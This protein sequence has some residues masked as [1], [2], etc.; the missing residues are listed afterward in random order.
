M[1]LGSTEAVKAAVKAGL[2]VSL[3][4]ISAVRDEVQNGSL[5]A[6]PVVGTKIKKPL[7]I[8]LPEGSPQQSPSR[9]F[10]QLLLSD[11]RV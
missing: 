11:Q 7:F 4:F 10:A 8:V 2:G 5:L 6:L 9:R 1:N 3:V